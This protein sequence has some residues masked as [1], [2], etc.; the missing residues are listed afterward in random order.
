MGV[1][2][3][4]PEQINQLPPADRASIMQLVGWPLISSSTLSNDSLP[5]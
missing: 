3:M 1:L 2:A 4:T 5:S